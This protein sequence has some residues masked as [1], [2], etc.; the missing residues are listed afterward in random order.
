MRALPFT[1][2][3]G[4]A[5]ARWLR[6]NA[7]KLTLSH[8]DYKAKTDGLPT[9]HQ[10][11]G[12]SQVEGAKRWAEAID[13]WFGKRRKDKGLELRVV[14]G[15]VRKAET[16]EE[17]NLAVQKLNLVGEYTGAQGLLTLLYGVCG[18]DASLCF[19]DNFDKSS[20]RDWCAAGDAGDLDSEALR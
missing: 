7:A 1:K 2:K 8:V 11:A 12:G 19:S 5:F 3:E 10:G 14:A 4:L 15:H 9:L 6:K 18:G 13:S 16:W 20:M 17:A